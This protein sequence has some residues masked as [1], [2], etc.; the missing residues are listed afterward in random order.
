[1]KA[2]RLR[3]LAV[4]SAQPS[5][6]APGIP[7]IA[8]SGVPGYEAD[9]THGLLAPANTPAAILELLNQETVRVLNREDVKEKLLNVGVEAVG[10]SQAAFAAAIRNDMTK[11]GKLIRDAGIRAD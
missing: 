2:G 10:S 11:W 9:S 1:V 3:A 5:A 8:A 7:T 6:L 4:T